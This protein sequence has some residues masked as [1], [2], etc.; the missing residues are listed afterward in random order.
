MAFYISKTSNKSSI[1]H[2]KYMLKDCDNSGGFLC[3]GSLNM[4]DASVL[5]NFE[6]MVFSTEPYLVEAFSKNFEHCWGMI[7]N[8]N[9]DV[10]NRTVLSDS[11]LVL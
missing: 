7:D 10:Y 5:N 6:D 11:N 4:S 3:M 8:A 2:Y 9:Q 1:M